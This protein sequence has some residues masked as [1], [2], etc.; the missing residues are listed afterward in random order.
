M[1]FQDTN[2]FVE[3]PPDVKFWSRHCSKSVFN[4]ALKGRMFVVE[5]FFVTH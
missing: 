5:Y 4:D 1:T 2:K 3:G